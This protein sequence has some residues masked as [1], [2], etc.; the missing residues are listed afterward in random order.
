MLA[1]FWPVSGVRGF[2]NHSFFNEKQHSK[3]SREV[4]SV[5]TRIRHTN[6]FQ[7]QFFIPLIQ[8]TFWFWCHVL[9]HVREEKKLKRIT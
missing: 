8:A 9:F 5:K 1:P 3:A 4:V 2:R 6:T 7:I